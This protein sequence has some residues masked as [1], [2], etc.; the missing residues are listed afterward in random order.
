[1]QSVVADTIC[2]DYRDILSSSELS[3]HALSIYPGPIVAA[4]SMSYSESDIEIQPCSFVN[5]EIGILR[6]NTLIPAGSRLPPMRE[7]KTRGA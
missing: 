2:G 7:S 4:F 6:I 1:M 5:R 3:A